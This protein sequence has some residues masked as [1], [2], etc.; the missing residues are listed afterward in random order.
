VTYRRRR[1][2]VGKASSVRNDTGVFEGGEIS[3]YYD[4]M[5]A[6]LCTMGADRGSRPSRRMAQA[7]D[8][9]VSTA[10]PQH[11]VPRR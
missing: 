3:I 8:A 9:F 1:G 4:P 10:S 2:Q 11:P 6:K 7:L 5:I